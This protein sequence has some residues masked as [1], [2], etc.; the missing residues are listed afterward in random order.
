MMRLTR[1]I[2]A[3]IDDMPNVAALDDNGRCDVWALLS[4]GRQLTMPV[5][6][7]FLDD[8]NILAAAENAV[9][10]RPPVGRNLKELWIPFY[11][12]RK[13]RRD[14]ALPATAVQAGVVQ[15]LWK[16]QAISSGPL[17]AFVAAP[18]LGNQRCIGT[19]KRSRLEIEQQVRRRSTLS[20]L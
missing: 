11:R 15:G 7:C 2:C 18:G 10:M 4:F 8:L 20:I 14:F 16:E 5:A 12:G 13:M 17:R 19:I 3:D 1:R 6:R 9:V